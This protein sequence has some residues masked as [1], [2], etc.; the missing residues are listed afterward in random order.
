M[1]EH[2]FR[3]IVVKA[4]DFYERRVPKDETMDLWAE[5]VK[6]IPD[7]AAGYIEDHITDNDMLP[8]NIPGFM[9]VLCNA[10]Q[11]A[12]PGTQE[13]NKVYKACPDCID[14][15]IWASKANESGRKYEYIFRCCRCRQNHVQAY[16]KAYKNELEL[17]GYE[18]TT[19]QGWK[20]SSQEKTKTRENFKQIGAM[21]F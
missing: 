13:A 1:I 2:R 18:I 5:K 14:G 20:V 17:Q 10:W 19:P 3:Q 6:G 16:P 8:K 9:W 4:C 7:Q 21:P 12:N 11:Q 15:I